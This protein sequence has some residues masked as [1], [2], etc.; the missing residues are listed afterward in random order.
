VLRDTERN[1]VEHTVFDPIADGREF[2]HNPFKV[3]PA[4]VLRQAIDIFSDEDS[5][6]ERRNDPLH[7]SIKLVSLITRA[8]RAGLGEPLAGE[9]TEHHVAP[10]NA[11]D[12]LAETRRGDGLQA[13]PLVNVAP[14]A[15]DR[16]GVVIARIRDFKPGLPKTQVQSAATAEHAD[17]ATFAHRPFSAGLTPV[18]KISPILS[19]PSGR[20]IVPKKPREADKK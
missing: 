20:L 10:A 13:S 15:S 17:R 3:S 9:T 19:I 5:W 11:R 1:G 12:C 7:L 6:P 14:V 18:I 16:R 2:G 8:L 4:K